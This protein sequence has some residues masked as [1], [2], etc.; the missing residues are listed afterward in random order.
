MKRKIRKVITTQSMDIVFVDK[1]I[2]IKLV[3]YDEYYPDN[4]C[5]SHI[6]SLD[7]NVL[8]AK[9]INGE[10]IQLGE[11]DNG[12]FGEDIL[13]DL[14]NWLSSDCDLNPFDVIFDESF[15]K[16]KRQQSEYI[17]KFIHKKDKEK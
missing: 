2:E 5:Y 11:Y 8:I 16:Q 13:W 1:L 4:E 9:D 12:S 10:E 15:M 7:G 14:T 17:N 3:S 6:R